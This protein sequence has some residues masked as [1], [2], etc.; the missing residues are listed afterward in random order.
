[1]AAILLIA[2]PIAFNVAFFELGRAFEY[3]A[4][5]RKE[6]DEILRRF[7]AGGSGLILRWEALLVSALL[8]L[9]L[10]VLVAVVLGASPVLTLL[11]RVVGGVAP[12]GPGARLCPW[13]L[14]RPGGAPP[15]P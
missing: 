11:S 2:V 12:P 5:L 13:A 14:A 3:P 7:N 6:P 10:A 1:M 9:P 4:I 8:M 15:D